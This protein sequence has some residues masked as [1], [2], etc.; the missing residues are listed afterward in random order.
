MINVD[1]NIIVYAFRYTLGR[2]TYAVSDMVE[3][4]IENWNVLSLRTR[5]LIRKEIET[6]IYETGQYGLEMDKKEWLKILEL[7]NVKE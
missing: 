1:E 7:P 4:L 6:A 2:S 5:L 3:V